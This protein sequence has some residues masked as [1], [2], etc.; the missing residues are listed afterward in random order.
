MPPAAGDIEPPEAFE[1]PS[2][3]DAG[4]ARVPEEGTDAGS[5]ME[6]PPPKFEGE[7]TLE[8]IRSFW[9]SLIQAVKARKISVGTFLAEGWPRALDGR[10]LTVAFKRS[11]M[12]HVN[13]VNRNRE[14]VEAAA[15]EMFGG[16]LRVVCEIEQNKESEAAS[17]DRD[18]PEEDARVQLALRIFEGEVIRR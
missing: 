2:V 11:G 8:A 9:D 14:T 18:P 1:A 6:K 16:P 15:A 17:E 5:G 10:Q 12:F 3:P 4:S 13:Q 7:L